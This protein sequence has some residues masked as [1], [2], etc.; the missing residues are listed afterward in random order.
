MIGQIDLFLVFLLIIISASIAGVLAGLLGVGGG[1]IIV[2]LLYYVMNLLEYDQS[3]I[4]HTAV[5][6]SLFI[7][8]PT[9]IR[10]S[11]EHRIRGSFDKE[12][13]KSWMVPIAVGSGL[14]SVAAS[15]SSFKVLTLLFAV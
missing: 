5:G 11:I 9:S 8:I 13:F 10:S 6:T 12:I 2:P 3:I 1:I 4:M 14:G 15:Y 7:I